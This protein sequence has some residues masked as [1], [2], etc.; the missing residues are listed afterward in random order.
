[1]DRGRTIRNAHLHPP[2]IERPHPTPH[3]GPPD[4]PT[5]ISYI[6]EAKDVLDLALAALQ[7]GETPPQ[8]EPPVYS[9][10]IQDRLIR[11]KPP[12]PQWHRPAPAA[13][14]PGRA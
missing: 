4:V 5:A 2:P 14:R 3:S 8:P 10:A 13:G 11:E 9:T 12:L 6:N 7:G 1:M